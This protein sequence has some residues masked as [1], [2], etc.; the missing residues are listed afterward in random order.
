MKSKKSETLR[1]I[2]LSFMVIGGFFLGMAQ[3]LVLPYYFEK[4]PNE[5][6]QVYNTYKFTCSTKE[7]AVLVHKYALDFIG[8]DTSKITVEMQYDVP[9]FGNFLLR[10]NKKILI[11]N[12]IKKNILGGYDCIFMES[13]N[14]EFELFFSDGFVFVN[15]KRK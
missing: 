7:D 9:I 15:Y 12:F 13:K 4:V 2:M 6:K 10:E 14:E 3:N 5:Y 8:I 1:L 11:I